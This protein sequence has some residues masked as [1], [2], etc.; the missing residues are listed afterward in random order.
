MR[1]P[2]EAVMS[3]A[4]PIPHPDKTLIITTASVVTISSLTLLG[5]IYFLMNQAVS[6][7]N[8]IKF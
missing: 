1:Q 7:L 2:Q 8:I 6:Y 4:P 3:F 5:M